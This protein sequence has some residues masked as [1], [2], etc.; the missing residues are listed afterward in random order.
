MKIAV[1]SGKGGTG[2]TT[3]AV[4]LF[5]ALENSVL[6][7][8]DTEEPNSHIFLE[9]KKLDSRV[10]TKGYPVIDYDKCNFCGKCGELCNFNAIIPTKKK[11][12]VFDD[13]CHDC[14]LCEIACPSNAISYSQKPL[15]EITTF[16]FQ[17]KTYL[18][19]KLN[20]GEVSG[21]KL[22]EELKES[23]DK[24]ET[25]IIDCPPGVACSTVTSLN[26]VDYAVIVIEPTPFGL[27]DMKMVVELLRNEKI[28]FGVV[29]NKA[30]LGDG[31]VL[32]Y[33]Q[34]EGIKLITEIPFQEI[35]AKLYSEGKLISN[36]SVTFHNKMDEIIRYISEE[37]K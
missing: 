14:G 25:V 7:D 32:E 37:V 5:H 1:L 2:K 3:V 4:N 12:I 6:I 28:P 26:G 22:I 20:I 19:G 30:D 13:L 29:I 16:S 23:T 18:S 31:A 9:G 27:S 17:E 15:G 8:T 34:E 24:E 21:V 11:V 33:L 35:Y 10:V 36:Y